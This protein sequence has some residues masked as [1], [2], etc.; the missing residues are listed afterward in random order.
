V[1]GSLTL[2]APRDRLPLPAQ[3]DDREPGFFAVRHE[4]RGPRASRLLLTHP[5]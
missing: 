4:Q 2:V 1:A 5:R 3:L